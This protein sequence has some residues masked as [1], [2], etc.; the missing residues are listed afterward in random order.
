[1]SKPIYK[2]CAVLLLLASIPWT[3]CSESQ[4][5]PAEPTPMDTIGTQAD[6]TEKVLQ[7]QGPVLVDFYTTWCGWCARLKP[8]L[9]SL[10]GEYAGRISFYRINVEESPETEVLAGTYRVNSFPHMV[11]FVDGK[12]VKRIAGF[13]HR[14]PLKK[15]LDRVLADAK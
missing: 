13:V 1:M 12:A 11:I 15:I 3:A 14:K 8:V 9:E 2:A 4:K 7:A 5:P 6:F 10:N